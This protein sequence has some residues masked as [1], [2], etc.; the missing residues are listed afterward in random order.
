[1]LTAMAGSTTLELIDQKHLE[2]QRDE[3]LIERYVR[4]DR[5]AFDE[6]VRLYQGR[7]AGLAYRLLGWSGDVE[8]VVQE[9]FL[10]VLRNLGRFR[11]QSSFKTWLMTI[12][13]NKCRSWRRKH[14]LKLK[15]LEISGFYSP[16][17]Q[18]SAEQGMM[19]REAYGRVRRTLNE[20]SM[21]HRE[22]VVL[23]YLEEM[24]IEEIAKILGLRR[25]VVDVRLS[26]ARAQLKTK[27]TDLIEDK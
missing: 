23:H 10:A 20:L 26:R 18:P 25:N 24:S 15:L 16:A 3:Q 5:S 19:D 1:M 27:L 9:V 13:V 21:R 14:L 22:V 17:P 4:G 6:L 7:V 11:G 8:D 12:T 2:V